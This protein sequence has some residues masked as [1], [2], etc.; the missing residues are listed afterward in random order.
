MFDKFSHALRIKGIGY[1]TYTRGLMAHRKPDDSSHFSP[2]KSSLGYQCVVDLAQIRRAQTRDK[3]FLLG[4]K[5]WIR[6]RDLV[7]HITRLTG[8]SL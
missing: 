4:R 8:A 3:R 5:R 7:R 2:L 1:T 6:L